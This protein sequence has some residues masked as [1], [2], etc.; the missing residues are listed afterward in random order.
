M[1]AKRKE[2]KL[3]YEKE[4]EEAE[5]GR[6]EQQKREEEWVRKVDE[7]RKTHAQA[8]GQWAKK[9]DVL[10]SELAVSR[11]QVE[12]QQKELSGSRQKEEALLSEWL[13]GLGEG[14]EGGLMDGD[15]D[16]EE[17]KKEEINQ[18]YHLH[19]SLANQRPQR[20]SQPMGELLMELLP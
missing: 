16:G 10:K 13:K 11:K 6:Q 5:R 3:K 12:R 20:F 7:E 4:H 17:M 18:W 15:G 9:A 8:V 19:G 2:Q 1:E 14:K